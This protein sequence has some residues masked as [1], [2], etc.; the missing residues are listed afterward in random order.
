MTLQGTPGCV[1]G[2]GLS[3]HNGGHIGATSPAV[4]TNKRRALSTGRDSYG[5]AYQ[6]S[7]SLSRT[8]HAHTAQVCFILDTA[9]HLIEKIVAR[10]ERAVSL[11]TFLNA[12]KKRL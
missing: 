11:V 2:P 10:A 1:A 7:E 8:T 12:K 3:K 4:H 9:A 6:R 5:H